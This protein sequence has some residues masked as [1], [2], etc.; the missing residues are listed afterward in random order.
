MHFD[1]V[2][3]VFQVICV[4]TSVLWPLI[5]CYFA[6]IATN[7]IS[8]IGYSAYD[9]NWFEYPPKLQKYMILIIARSQ[10]TIYFTG[11]NLVYCTLEVFAKV[12]IFQIKKSFNKRKIISCNSIKLFF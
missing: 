11:F 10:E 6:T 4:L 3:L 12:S 9:T 5:Y 7:R 2:M 8:M 1:F